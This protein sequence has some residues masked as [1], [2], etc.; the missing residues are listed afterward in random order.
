MSSSPQDAWT[1]SVLTDLLLDEVDALGHDRSWLV[2]G[3]EA[4]LP[5]SIDSD[6]VSW[7]PLDVRERSRVGDR[8]VVVDDVADLVGGVILPAPPDRALTRRLLLS[9]RDALEAG[10]ILLLGGA[11]SE[12]GKSAIQ[13]ATDVFGAPVDSGYRRKHRLAR[14]TA[15][16]SGVEPAWADQPGVRPGSWQR[17]TVRLADED[18]GLETQPGVFAGPRLDDGTRLLLDAMGVPPGGRVLDVGCGAGVV[19]L[20]AAR[21]GAKRVDAVDVGL[22][23]VETTRRNLTAH[24]VVGNVFASDL[25]DA[26]QGR[27]YNLIVSNPPFHA[28]KKVDLSFGERL[29]REAPRHLEPDGHLMLVANVFL[30]YEPLLR[31]VFERVEI[32]AETPSF[33]VFR[34]SGVR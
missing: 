11:N 10:G 17:F 6:A 16:S 24:E 7:R 27:R 14:F 22:L 19:A 3:G 15:G 29:I 12:G 32:P 1:G 2:L 21:A 31:E 13:D 26:V 25:Y 20:A 9:A 4:E 28:G 33:R 34:A 8:V 18:L 23:A 30:A 5:N